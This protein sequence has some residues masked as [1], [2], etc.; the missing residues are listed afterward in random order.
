MY[1]L[2]DLD[3]FMRARTFASTSHES[4]TIRT[5]SAE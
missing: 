2:D 5:G 1:A 3:A 4:T